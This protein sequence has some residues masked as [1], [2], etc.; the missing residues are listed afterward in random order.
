MCFSWL[1]YFQFRKTKLHKTSYF[2][3][4][5]NYCLIPFTKFRV[6]LHD[7]YFSFIFLQ[8]KYYGASEYEK[9]Q[10]DAAIVKYQ[11]LFNIISLL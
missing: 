1:I 2:F 3:C 4:F 11:V 10:Y 9:G 7:I 5:N 6:I 8:V